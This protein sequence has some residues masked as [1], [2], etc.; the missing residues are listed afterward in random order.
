[1]D[2]YVTWTRSIRYVPAVLN[3]SDK[4]MRPKASG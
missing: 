4:I 2:V 1:V 3:D